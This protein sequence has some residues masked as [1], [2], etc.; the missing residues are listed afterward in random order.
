MVALA[1][2]LLS[3]CSTMDVTLEKGESGTAS[4]SAVA[5]APTDVSMTELIAKTN[6]AMLVACA[7]YSETPNGDSKFR[8]STDAKQL[9][10]SLA[11]G[12]QLIGDATKLAESAKKLLETVKGW[13]PVNTYTAARKC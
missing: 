7:A 4:V 6:R 5:K 1:C 10:D 2:V 12:T 9:G 13:F 8:A 11:S 3:A